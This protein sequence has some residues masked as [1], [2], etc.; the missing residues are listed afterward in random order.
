MRYKAITLA[1]IVLFLIAP[2]LVWGQKFL[3]QNTKTENKYPC[4][5][6]APS[7]IISSASI[8]DASARNNNLITELRM[9]FCALAT[10]S[11]QDLFKQNPPPFNF[12]IAK[13]RLLLDQKKV[14]NF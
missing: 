6:K 2:T 9:A 4:V 10:K 14:C 7:S 3:S 13:T 12:N 11:L 1:S 5:I 8:Q